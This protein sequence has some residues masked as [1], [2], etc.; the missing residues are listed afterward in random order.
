MTRYQLRAVRR[1]ARS[2][3]R[4]FAGYWCA[5]S[6]DTYQELIDQACGEFGIGRSHP[7]YPRLVQAIERYADLIL[8]R[9]S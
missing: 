9:M 4:Y 8:E 1:V 3:A 7:A 5:Q 2:D 6:A